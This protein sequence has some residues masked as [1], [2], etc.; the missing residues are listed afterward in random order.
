MG[1]K[2]TPKESER[3]G[4]REAVEKVPSQ[5]DNGKEMVSQ[6]KEEERLADAPILLFVLPR[7]GLIVFEH[8]T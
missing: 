6:E 1:A 4:E 3:E 2:G 5:R 7:N 8:K